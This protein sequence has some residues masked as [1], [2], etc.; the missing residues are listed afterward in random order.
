MTIPTDKERELWTQSHLSA[1][2]SD[3]QHCAECGFEHP[4]PTLR[5]LDALT[6]AEA[7]GGYLRATCQKV[8][9]LLITT[10][11]GWDKF[12]AIQWEMYDALL[13][14]LVPE[15]R[16]SKLP[17]PVPEPEDPIWRRD[18]LPVVIEMNR[19][20]ADIGCQDRIPVKA[21]EKHLTVC[22]GAEGLVS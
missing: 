8:K 21:I 7:E 10:I 1:G 13:G 16:D 9:D 4:C 3:R 15:L 17:A 11:S 22:P 6:A 19:L 20:L 18:L 5:L 12:A 14:A 2:Y